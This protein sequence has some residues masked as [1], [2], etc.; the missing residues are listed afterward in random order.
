MLD[1]PEFAAAA[2]SNTELRDRQQGLADNTKPSV[3]KVRGKLLEQGRT[4]TPL[5]A[6]DNLTIRLKIYA[7]GGEN[8]LHAHPF[9][10]HSFVILQGLAEFYGPE[11]E[12][13]KLGAHEGIMLPKGNLYWFN[14]T[15]EEP[16]VMLRIGNPN[17]KK[18]GTPGRIN[19]EG[20]EMRGDS[21]ENKTVP[22][23]FKADEY[24]G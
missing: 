8:E 18:M 5:A 4:D 11:G 24:F 2:M 12:A 20:K 23:I 16:L 22:I 1:A 17:Y 13:I 7:S 9:E 10:D 3:F 14:A 19:A 21:E 6:T 15:S